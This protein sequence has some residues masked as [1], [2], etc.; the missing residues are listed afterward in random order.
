MYI[1]YDAPLSVPEST[2]ILVNN[3]KGIN[4]SGAEDNRGPGKTYGRD[5][6]YPNTTE[7]DYYTSKGFGIIRL[8]FDLTRVYPIPYSVL[9]PIEL[10]Y[11]KPIV[12]YCLLK[13]TVD[14]PNKNRVDN[15]PDCF[16]Y[17]SAIFQDNKKIFAFRTR[18]AS[19][20]SIHVKIK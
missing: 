13:G 3:Y 5:Y 15:H 11:M 4:L 17:I 2:S 1:D 6:V 16:L 12:D 9:D 20:L 18:A 10:G 14:V 19:A 7:I 8:P